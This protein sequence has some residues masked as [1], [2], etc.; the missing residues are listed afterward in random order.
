MNGIPW[1]IEEEKFLRDNYKT[2]SDSKLAKALNRG[3]SSIQIKR[4]NL[5]LWKQIDKDKKE[6]TAVIECLTFAK[7]IEERGRP[8]DVCN[9]DDVLKKRC[10]GCNE[11]D[12]WLRV[13]WRRIRSNLGKAQMYRDDEII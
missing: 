13:A 11:L 5:G 4:I 2:M 12:K 6:E 1:T 3:I 9:M 8:C 7:D 10:T